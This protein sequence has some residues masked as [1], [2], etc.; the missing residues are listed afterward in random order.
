[1]ADDTTTEE[2]ARDAVLVAYREIIGVSD[3]AELIEAVDESFMSRV[4]DI[5]WTHQFDR[6]RKPFIRDIRAVVSEAVAEALPDAP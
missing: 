1:M 3:D 5:A 4:F 6:D 2:E